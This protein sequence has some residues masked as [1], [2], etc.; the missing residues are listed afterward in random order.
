MLSPHILPHPNLWIYPLPPSVVLP[1]A[2]HRCAFTERSLQ[3][4]DATLAEKAQECSGLNQQLE[5]ASRKLDAHGAALQ[6]AVEDARKQIDFNVKSVLKQATDQ[7]L[8]SL[9]RTGDGS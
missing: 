1:I 7:L 9:Q 2:R 6:A 8:A 5:Q 3:L 4:A